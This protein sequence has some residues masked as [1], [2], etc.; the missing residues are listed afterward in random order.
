MWV[1]TDCIATVLIIII[2]KAFPYNKSKYLRPRN[3]MSCMIDCKA[4]VKVVG[5]DLAKS[6]PASLE[7]TWGPVALARPAHANATPY[8]NPPPTSDLIHDTITITS[9]SLTILLLTARKQSVVEKQ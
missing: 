3:A 9:N 4:Y 7:A 8:L 5:A 6:I 1:G 2:G